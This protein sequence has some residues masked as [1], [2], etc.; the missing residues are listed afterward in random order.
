LDERKGHQVARKLYSLKVTGT[1]RR[2]IDAQKAGSISNL[3][4]TIQVL[5]NSGYWIHYKL[6]KVAIQESGEN[7]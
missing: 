6:V 1:A 7:R 2:L 4:N 3:N 5:G